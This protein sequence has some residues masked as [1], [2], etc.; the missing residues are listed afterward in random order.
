M[1]YVDAAL[2]IFKIYFLIGLPFSVLIYLL[3][4]YLF[5]KNYKTNKKKRDLSYFFQQL[6]AIFVIPGIWPL[7]VFGFI[8]AFFETLGNA[9]HAYYRDGKYFGKRYSEVKQVFMVIKKMNI[10]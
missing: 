8:Y 5:C 4:I 7:L 10:I 2:N 1:H 3:L 6:L 9:R